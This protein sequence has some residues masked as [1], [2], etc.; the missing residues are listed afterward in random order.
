MAGSK[1]TLAMLGAPALLALALV[2]CGDDA[3]DKP[4]DGSGGGGGGGAEPCPAPN[5]LVG[6]SCLEP[7]VQDDGCPA[8]ML[9]L[10]DGSC[11]PAGIAPDG[12]AEGF[13]HDGD[14]GCEPILPANPC[15]DGQLAVPGESECHPVMDCGSGKWGDI[16]VDA[17]TIYVDA[18]Y[19]GG[20]SNG[21]EAQPFTTIGDAAAAA[22]GGALIAVAA[23]SYPA[24]VLIEKPLRLWGVCP[25][26]VALVG[27]GTAVGALEIHTG[28]SGSEVVGLAITSEANPASIAVSGV[29]DVT[30]ERLWLHDGSGRGINV[31]NDLGPTSLT[32][33]DTLIERSHDIGVYVSGAEATLTGLVIRDTL[34]RQSDQTSGRGIAIVPDPSSNAPTTANVTGSL[35]ER[36][37]ELGVYVSGSEATLTGLVIRDTLPRQS[38]LAFG[39]GIGIQLASSTGTSASVSISGSLIERSHDIGV[40]VGA[41]Q[42]TLTGVVV[43]DTMPDASSQSSGRSIDIQP[44]PAT[45]APSTAIVESSL[46]E[47]SREVGVFVGASEATLTGVVVRD[48]LPR[49]SD[50]GAGRGVHIQQDPWTG[51]PS[52]VRITGSLVER[53]HDTGV[54]LVGSQATLTGIAV[55]QTLAQASDGLFGD[56][57]VIV[58]DDTLVTSSIESCLSEANARAGLSNFGAE[59][60]LGATALLCNAL[61]LVGEPYLE[62]PFSFDDRGGNACGC[63]DAIDTCQAA[64]AGLTPPEPLDEGP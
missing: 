38:D 25:E 22:S 41:S 60:A 6:D 54:V 47:T 57:I 5:R 32:I 53:C 11:Q 1:R 37:H 40:F 30:L 20:T 10:D 58:S 13:V 64:T 62:Q 8:G 31:Q 48:T 55:R 28:A 36:C 12:C 34:P 14:A 35:V 21:S 9:G 61:D 17:A 3:A 44:D 59:V 15:P 51:A 24:D 27:Q 18:S 50:Q 52:T 46:V 39:R 29:E 19:G 33:R 49:T 42:A 43:R 4:P 23:G 26:R 45:G 2:G 63:D 7:G 56:G 16:P